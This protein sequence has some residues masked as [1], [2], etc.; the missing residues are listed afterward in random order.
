MI[1]RIWRGWIEPEQ[2]DAYEALV[3]ETIAPGIHARGV[4]GLRTTEVLR[5]VEPDGQEVEFMTIMT[6]DDWAAV[7]DFGGADPTASYVPESAR[8]LLTRFDNYA[9][10]YEHLAEHRGPVTGG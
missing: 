6:F 9:A 2:A 5:R 3:N 7:E 1:K 10:H 8:L 4:S